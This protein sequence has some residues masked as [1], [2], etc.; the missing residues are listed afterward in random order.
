MPWIYRQ[1]TGLLTAPDGKPLATGYSGTGVG[2][3]E[4]D[5]ESVRNI[6]PIPCGRYV[7]G[8]ARV[9]IDLGPVVMDLDPIPPT[10]TYGRSLFRIHGN[11]AQNDAS[12]GCIILDRPQRLAISV[13]R[14]RRLEVTE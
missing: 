5:M 4:P 7:I 9:S 6:G 2:R 8:R 1:S 13:S 14:D 10:E 3:N 11:N 12:R